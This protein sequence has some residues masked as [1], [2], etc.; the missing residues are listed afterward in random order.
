MSFYVLRFT[1]CHLSRKYK[2]GWKESKDKGFE[3]PYFLRG[4][5]K[6]GWVNSAQSLPPFLDDVG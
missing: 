5:I 1:F 4:I 2:K 6:S 3:F